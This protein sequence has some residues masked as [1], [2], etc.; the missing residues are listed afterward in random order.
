MAVG[1]SRERLRSL[2]DAAAAARLK[3]VLPA[4]R[5]IL[6]DEALGQADA[7]DYS[8][9]YTCVL[10]MVGGRRAASCN[11]QQRTLLVTGYVGSVME[12]LRLEQIVA[13][14]EVMSL[15]PR[16]MLELSGAPMVVYKYFESV[17][18]LV[19]NWGA[20]SRAAP[21]EVRKCNCADPRLVPFHGAGAEHVVT[22]DVRIVEN[23]A[24]R[25]LLSRGVKYR[26]TYVH[27]FEEESVG[28]PGERMKA[29]IVSMVDAGCWKLAKQ[30]SDLNGIEESRFLPWVSTVNA[31]ARD[32]LG[33][34]TTEE[35]HEIT[36]ATEARLRWNL[37]LTD[38]V[39]KLRGRY[40]ISVA[41]KETSVAVFTCRPFWEQRVRQEVNNSGVYVWHCKG[42]QEG[43][44]GVRRP[45]AATQEQPPGPTGTDAAPPPPPPLT[46]PR[47]LTAPGFENERVCMFNVLSGE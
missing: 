34:M 37:E 21:R 29:D 39:K 25:T 13:S 43:R 23:L 47:M 4:L 9:I 16:E 5:H 12:R 42:A 35:V 19:C 45:G 26:D 17:G 3:M 32:A 1:T 44:K 28:T 10:R 15:L 46:P 14:E 33:A 11:K 36:E 31:R 24:L 20:A 30:Q 6:D 18:Q 22:K 41:D 27:L 38:E 8:N 40:V 2:I 7:A